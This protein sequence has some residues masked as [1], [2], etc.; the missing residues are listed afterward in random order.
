MYGAIYP[1][2]NI[3]AGDALFDRPVFFVLLLAICA[4]FFLFQLTVLHMSQRSKWLRMD[5]KTAITQNKPVLQL[6]E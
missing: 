5:Y 3:L 1:Q 6:L 4:H 2:F